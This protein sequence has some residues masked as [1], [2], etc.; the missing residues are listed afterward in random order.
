MSYESIKDI[1]VTTHREW[2][3]YRV[4]HEFIKFRGLTITSKQISD[5]KEFVREFNFEQYISIDA[6]AN[7]QSTYAVLLVG[8][9]TKYIT[10]TVDFQQFMTKIKADNIIIIHFVP[11]ISNTIHV[12]IKKNGWDN[13]L[14][15]YPHYMFLTVYPLRVKYPKHTIISQEQLSIDYVQ[16]NPK[17]HTK[18]SIMDTMS[19]WLGAKLGDILAI[20]RKNP[21]TGESQAYRVVTNRI[22]QD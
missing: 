19:V 9:D 1:T 11:K 15:L 12:L 21:A 5:K 14:H 2:N 6:V 22:I 10:H 17:D 4:I 8:D 18:I 7:D 3:V 20:D 16:G 13:K